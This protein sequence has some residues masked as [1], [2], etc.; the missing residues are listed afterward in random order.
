MSTPRTPRRYG[1][2]GMA[3]SRPIFFNLP[4]SLPCV[5]YL[6]PTV[7]PT[8]SPRLVRHFTATPTKGLASPTKPT[9]PTKGLATGRTQRTQTTTTT[10]TTPTA[11]GVQVE[12]VT[13]TVTTIKNVE[14][15]GEQ[16]DETG[17]E[18]ANETPH[19]QTNEATVHPRNSRVPTVRK[20]LPIHPSKLSFVG[21]KRVYVVTRAQRPGV[22]NNWPAVLAVTKGVKD[23]IFEARADFADAKEVYRVAYEEGT[24]SADPIPGGA[25]DTSSYIDEPIELDEL[26]L[27]GLRNLGLHEYYIPT[28]SELERPTTNYKFY[29]VTKGEAV[30]IYGNWH[31]AAVRTEHVKSRGSCFR[32]CDSW[33]EALIGYTLA[34]ENGEIEVFPIPGGMFDIPLRHEDP[35]EL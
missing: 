21:G 27:M 15:E 4:P 29:L 28:P 10:T 30:G 24:I 33:R 20:Y 7:P 16:E 18:I 31:Q 35:E 2:T 23:P 11:F 34:Y 1:P 22:Y 12:T 5:D 25:F 3:I 14:Q 6:P 26:D 13:H 17:Y 8:S 32:K 19:R 9:S